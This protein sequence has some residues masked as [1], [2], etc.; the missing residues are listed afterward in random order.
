MII[1]LLKTKKINF[2]LKIK[3][4]NQYKFDYIVLSPGID[5]KKCKLSNYLLKIKK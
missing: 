1:P 4:I 5:I 2:F 3:N